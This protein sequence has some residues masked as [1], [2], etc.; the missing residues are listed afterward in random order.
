MNETPS[1][2][3]ERSKTV[4]INKHAYCY[5]RGTLKDFSYHHRIADLITLNDDELRKRNKKNPHK[6]LLMRKTN[7]L[8][9]DVEVRTRD[10][11]KNINKSL[12]L[13]DLRR[14]HHIR[15]WEP[16]IFFRTPLKI[17]LLRR[18]LKSI[19]R[20]P[21]KSPIAWSIFVK[22]S[23][24]ANQVYQ[25]LHRVKELKSLALAYGENYR[26][27]NQEIKRIAPFTRISQ[28]IRLELPAYR[29]VENI[30]EFVIDPNW[31]PLTGLDLQRTRFGD[32][33]ASAISRNLSWKMLKVLDLSYNE[34]G[35]KG[36][37]ALASNPTW[38][39]LKELILG[40]NILGV[41]GIRALAANRSWSQLEKLQ[42]ASCNIGDEEVAGLSSNTTWKC[43]L[44][45][46]LSQN[47]IKDNGVMMLAANGTWIRLKKLNL[48]QN[49]IT[50]ESAQLLAASRNWE[51]I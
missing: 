27:T 47:H 19:I 18:I 10:A 14:I 15:L 42:L 37:V 2:D 40:G 7:F 39:N 4:R 30:S 16:D 45:L 23:S 34:I 13:L 6:L 50:C 21:S 25:L 22:C 28:T 41:I 49:L 1:N 48:S 44:E 51:I 36:I 20:K 17:F 29:R 3:R 26:L 46:D 24:F 33:G 5:S 8:K 12:R 9:F 38:I 32:E 43:L 31:A 35:T 11:W